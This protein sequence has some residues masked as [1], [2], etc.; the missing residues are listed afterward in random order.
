VAGPDGDP[1]WLTPGTADGQPALALAP[2]LMSARE[3]RARHA[4]W[5]VDRFRRQWA[6][7]LGS[8]AEHW[9]TLPTDGWATRPTLVR[10]GRTTHVYEVKVARLPNPELAAGYDFLYL[11]TPE[12]RDGRVHVQNFYP[13]DPRSTEDPLP[14]QASLDAARSLYVVTDAD[15]HGSGELVA[16]GL[17][18]LSAHQLSPDMRVDGHPVAGLVGWF[19]PVSAP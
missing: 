6:R 19:P 17:V 12:P 2:W 15:R 10:T 18:L 1:T 16:P 5:L 11:V 13:A 4:R 3:A 9:G 7:W 14:S 8:G